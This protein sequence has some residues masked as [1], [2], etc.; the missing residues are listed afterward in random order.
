[1]IDHPINPCIVCLK[2][3]L[4]KA[5]AIAAAKSR[6][7]EHLGFVAYAGAEVVG[8]SHSVVIAV[9]GYLLVT[10]LAAMFAIDFV[11]LFEE[12]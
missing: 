6:P 5:R 3:R 4:A 1:M 10:G 7:A 12:L 9:A 11:E 8:A 2:A